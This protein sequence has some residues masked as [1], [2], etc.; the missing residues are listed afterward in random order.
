[1]SNRLAPTFPT[2]GRNRVAPVYFSRQAQVGTKYAPPPAYRSPIYL[3]LIPNNNSSRS[4]LETALSSP[5]TIILPLP[6]QTAIKLVVVAFILLVV[7][8]DAIFWIFG[9]SL[10]RAID[11]SLANAERSSGDTV[12]ASVRA[13]ARAVVG[14]ADEESILSGSLSSA[15]TRGG[16]RT[17]ERRASSARESA[18][19]GRNLLHAARK[20]VR[21]SMAF[22][23]LM[24]FQGYVLLTFSCS[25]GYGT[26]APLVLFGVQ[27]SV[28]PIVWH[29]V[30]IQLHAGRSTRRSG[31][32]A[33]TASRKTATKH[34]AR[35]SQA[36]VHVEVDDEEEAGGVEAQTRA[37]TNANSAKPG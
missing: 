27:M 12:T 8:A 13:S 2:W 31:G 35:R 11:T 18:D 16:R 7:V 26:G 1:M 24:S 14:G 33:A 9:T 19:A 15:G 34:T 5:V 3:A 21:R 37:N 28:L 32:S 25:T 22:C 23:G 4:F 30:H 36:L 6:L 29:M 17:R 20:K 10:L